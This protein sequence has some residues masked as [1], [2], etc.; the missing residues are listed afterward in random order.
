MEVPRETVARL[1][2]ALDTLVEQEGMY[3]RGGY[4]DLSA[5][6]RQRADPLVQ[7]LVALAADPAVADEFRPRVTAVL[8]RSAG[9]AEFLRGK[10]E[11]LAAEIRGTDQARQRAAQIAPAYAPALPRAAVISRFQAA[12]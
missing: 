12:G 1:L 11:D 9:H 2:A 4:Y 7:R 5:E 6:T 3:L 10:L 8:E